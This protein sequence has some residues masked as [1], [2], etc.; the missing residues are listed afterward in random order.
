MGPTVCSPR[1][2]YD[3]GV[4]SAQE[5]LIVA[6]AELYLD[7]EIRDGLPRLAER[8]LASGL[9]RHAV[10]TLW[11]TQVTPV[12]HWNLKSV[13]GEWAGFDRHWLLS[14]V[15]RRSAS[16][17]LERLPLLGSLLHRFRA[18]GAEREFRLAQFLA[19]RLSGVPEAARARR[20]AVWQALLGV[21]YAVDA[22]PPLAPAAQR[23][24][25]QLSERTAQRLVARF[26]P[27]AGELLD[28]FRSI[29]DAL[30]PLLSRPELTSAAE[31]NVA[32]W[33][34]RVALRDP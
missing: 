2:R 6:L 28:E 31:H 18:H 33:L 16:A 10:E 19:E 8:M 14:E 24:A 23:T 30:A 34:D 27:D 13:A 12:V 25:E 9:S 15:E 29:C 26:Q 11:R 20:V 5:E 1:L 3:P 32:E 21:Y 17:G 7:T 4:T 22:V